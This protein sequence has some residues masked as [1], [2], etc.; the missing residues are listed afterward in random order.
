[1]QAALPNPD[2]TGFDYASLNNQR[3]DIWFQNAVRGSDQLRQRVAWALSQIMVVSQVTLA[4]RY[5][6]GLADYYDMLARDAFGDFRQLIED[7]TLHPMMG[8]YLSMLG[9]QKP[10]RRDATSGPTRT[11]RASSCSCSR[12]VWSQ[13]NADGTAEA[14]RARTADPDLRPDRRRRLRARFTGWKWACTAGSPGAC[15]FGNTRATAANQ[16]LPMQAFAEQHA[17]GAKQLL[18]LSERREESRCRPAR[19]PRRTSPT[20]STTSSTTRT[21]DR[22]SLAS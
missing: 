5:P 22:S 8:V 18:T 14:R 9:N 21:S 4:N 17:T 15:D 2:A 11:T 12:S 1:M 20:R 3:Q 16:I 7:V 10:E 13:L 19:P 6:F